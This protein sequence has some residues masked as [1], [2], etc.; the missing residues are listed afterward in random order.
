MQV[1]GSVIAQTH[2]H[3]HKHTHKHAPVWG[4]GAARLGVGREW[5]PEGGDGSE[6][7]KKV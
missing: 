7:M 4:L 2:T 3:K 1:E 5:G 6:K